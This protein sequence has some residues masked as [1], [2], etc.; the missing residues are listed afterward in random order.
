MSKHWQNTLVHEVGRAASVVGGLSITVSLQVSVVRLTV[1]PATV[2]GI[3]FIIESLKE[4]YRYGEVIF[5][6]LGFDP[7]ASIMRWVLGLRVCECSIY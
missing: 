6:M 1:G 7:E 3:Q 4:D 5:H 2:K